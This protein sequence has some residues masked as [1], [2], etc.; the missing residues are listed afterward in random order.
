M[1]QAVFRKNPQSAEVIEAAKKQG[2]VA[3][4]YF[5]PIVLGQ[6]D[7]R[8]EE[9]L[10]REGRTLEGISPQERLIL[11][12]AALNKLIDLHLLR[13]K[14]RFNQDEAQVSK[15]EIDEEWAVITRRFRTED[16][17]RSALQHRG[18]SEKELRYRLAA[19]KAS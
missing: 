10:W 3:R 12:R 5:Q 18:W 17:F 1:R 13:L 16:E 7:R 11:R 2:V 19:R 8:V 4:V 9:D 6:V 15:E 14:V